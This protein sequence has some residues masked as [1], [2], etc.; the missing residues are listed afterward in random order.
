MNGLNDLVDTEIWHHLSRGGHWNEGD[1]SSRSSVGFTPSST[2]SVGEPTPAGS[3]NDGSANSIGHQDE[4][5]NSSTGI[6]ASKATLASAIEDVVS[7]HVEAIGPLTTWVSVEALAKDN[8]ARIA[9]REKVSLAKQ[10]CSSRSMLT[11]MI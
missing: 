2:S 6:E 1:Q 4:D 10:P 3:D 7:S 11:T 5:V 8:I 9:R